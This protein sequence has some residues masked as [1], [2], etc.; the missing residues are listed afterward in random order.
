MSG[1]VHL[2]IRIASGDETALVEF[3]RQYVNLVFSMALHV[4]HDH[5]TAEEVTQDVFLTLWR[6]AALYDPARGSV[7]SWLLTIARR[8]AIDYHRRQA[9][10]PLRMDEI[11][12]GQQPNVQLILPDLDLR[13]AVAAL[14]GDQQECVTMVYFG[15]LTHTEVAERLH[16]PLGTVKSRI[17]LALRRLRQTITV[18]S[19][20]T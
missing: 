6:R 3:H 10:L 14:P 15:G 12:V 11:A 19:E 2:L 7:K 16:V 5:A 9:H 8:R 17:R 20:D 4:L 1:D 13:D 18:F